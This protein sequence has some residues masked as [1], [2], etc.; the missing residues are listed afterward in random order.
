MAKFNQRTYEIMTVDNFKK[1]Y[2]EG[3]PELENWEFN[4]YWQ[5]NQLAHWY[6]KLVKI[7]YLD[8]IK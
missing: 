3:Q 8:D 7:E 5:Y 4:Y 1:L 6:E 2:P